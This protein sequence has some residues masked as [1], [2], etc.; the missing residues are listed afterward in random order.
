MRFASFVMKIEF[1]VT[2]MVVNRGPTCGN[3][4]VPS[5]ASN[6]AA[7]AFVAASV[8]PQ[9]ANCSYEFGCLRLQF[10]AF[11]AD[12]WV[13]GDQYCLWELPLKLPD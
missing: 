9:T 7:P 10:W 1:K 11:L 13:F 5:R 4:N 3:P 8:V 6:Y 2:P 12:Y